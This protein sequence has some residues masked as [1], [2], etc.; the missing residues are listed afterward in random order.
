MEGEGEEEGEREARV[1]GRREREGESQEA[2]KLTWCLDTQVVVVVA[3]PSSHW[4]R[5]PQYLNRA[6]LQVSE[7]PT[8]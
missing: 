4:W 6:S 3:R 7:S 8:L 5:Q 2:K 1:R